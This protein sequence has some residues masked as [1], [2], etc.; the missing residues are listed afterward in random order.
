MPRTLPRPLL[1]PPV[2]LC[3][4]LGLLTA[5]CS[6]RAERAGTRFNWV[7]AKPQ[8]AFDPHGAPEPVRWSLERLLTRGLIEQ[9]SSGRIVPAAALR[10]NVSDEGRTYTFQLDSALAFTDGAPCRSR[11]FARALAGGLNRTDHST[12][13]WLL[14]AVRGVEQVRPGKPVGPLGIETPDSTTLVLR[15][16]NPDSMLLEKLAVPGASSA[17]A[18]RPPAPGW[19]GAVGL[20]PYRIAVS[21]PARL[22]LVL[23]V[24]RTPW[25][26]D[27]VGVR[28][29][30][31]SARP[32]ASMRAGSVDLLWPVPERLIGE[33]LPASYRIHTAEA[34]PPRRLLLVMRAD[35]PPTSRSATRFAL[36]HAINRA[37]LVRT[38]GASGQELTE[39]L[40]G[41]GPFDFPALDATEVA[42]W[43]ERAKLGH[44]FHLPVVFDADGT[45][46]TAARV[47]Q[48]E[49]SRLGIYL[50]LRPLRGATLASRLLQG[51]AHLM[52]VETQPLVHSPVAELAA[53]VMPMRGPPVGHFRTGW[54]TREFDPWIVPGAHGTGSAAFD[55]SESQRRLAEE[56]VALPIA[57]LSWVWIQREGA[58][59]M[60]FHPRFGPECL[61]ERARQASSTLN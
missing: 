52:L 37:G 40:A 19:R 53:L 20:G 56:R 22:V 59:S 23:A 47:L 3:L 28:F 7:V 36:A 48:G 18:E 16:S 10:W 57:R 31:G 8:P 4:A 46:A 29:M 61:P 14:G 25:R 51:G 44:S 33:P 55:A 2:L 54:R 11:D 45:G 9:D 30:L 15:L 43:M 49:W 38:L 50:E 12:Y 1:H 60:G 24:P 27:T 34:D 13:N 35:L 17:W 5:G 41:A 32:L 39:W 42:T 26:P 21:E 58:L 6:G